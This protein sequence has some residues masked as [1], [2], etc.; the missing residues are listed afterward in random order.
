MGLSIKFECACVVYSYKELLF[1][2][3][4][5]MHFLQPLKCFSN[6]LLKGKKGKLIPCKL[7]LEIQCSIVFSF[8]KSL[9]WKV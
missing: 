4:N 7:R 2:I 5:S 3:Y 6:I 8:L 9:I 1:L